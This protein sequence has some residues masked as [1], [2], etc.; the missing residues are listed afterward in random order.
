MLLLLMVASN[1]LVWLQHRWQCARQLLHNV[2]CYAGR[3]RDAS[4]VYHV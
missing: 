2:A 3:A 1:A 4:D